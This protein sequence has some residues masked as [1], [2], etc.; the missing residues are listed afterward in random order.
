[1]PKWITTNWY[2]VNYGWDYESKGGWVAAK[3]ERFFTPEEK[4]RNSLNELIAYLDANQYTIKAVIPK[5]QGLGCHDFSGSN[6]SSYGWGYGVTPIT[7]FVVLAQQERE[8]T[9]EEY[10]RLSRV[11][12]LKNTLPTL[13][14]KCEKLQQAVAADEQKA[15]DISEKKKLLGGA[16]YLLGE[17]EFDSR[18]AAEAA[19][20]ALQAECAA[21]CADLKEAKGELGRM[22]SEL[23]GLEA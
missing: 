17:K 3:T 9:A 20:V 7:G 16:K 1:M 6:N 22:E 14:Q 13:R 19:L 23:K 10:D 8:V 15:M 21:R 4:L 11:Q 2:S 18:E 5:T 12:A